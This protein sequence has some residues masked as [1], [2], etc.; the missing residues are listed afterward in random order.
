[1]VQSLPSGRSGLRLSQ[2]PVWST[3][4]AVLAGGAHALSMGMPG[5][6]QPLGTLQWLSLLTMAWLMDRVPHVRRAAW[7]GWVFGTVSLCGT[8]WWLY[9][10]LHTYGH[11]PAWMAAVSVLALCAMLSLYWAGAGWLYVNFRT[12]DLAWGWRALAFGASVMLAELARAQWFTGFPWGVGGYAHVDSAL[13][14]LA[15]WIGVYGIGALSATLAMAVAARKPPHWWPDWQWRQ[16]GAALV[17]SLIVALALP[18]PGMRES[19]RDKP[20]V[21][22]L[23]QGNVPQDEKFQGRRAWSLTWYEAA[24]RS[25]EQGLVVTPETSLP[26]VQ[27]QLPPGYWQGLV[28]HFA[29]GERAAL[30]GM[31]LYDLGVHTNSVLGLA[32]PVPPY[33]YDKHHL[34]PFGEFVPPLFQWFTRMM[35]IPLGEFGRG[36]VDPPSMAWQG[37]RLA[38]MICYEDLFGEELAQ[39]FQDP[40]TSPT[41]L[42]NLSN[43]AWFGDTIALDQHLQISRLRALEFDRPVIRATNTGSTAIID[44]QARVTHRLPASQEG[45]LQG[46]VMGRSGTLTPYAR[47]VGEYGLAPLWALAIGLLWL[48]GR[49]RVRI[50]WRAS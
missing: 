38:P 6:G 8:V 34:V 36:R 3:V 12:R 15:P 43:L 30:I 17:L 10:S 48:P 29:Q 2:S 37:Q 25:V 41:V 19:A 4:A 50:D 18:W 21:V 5:D 32:G 35:N 26:Y 47:W 44:A 1:M 46:E 20:M 42:V 45:V 24:L 33:R 27:Q 23:V 16:W 40:A 7:L 9:I 31:P 28:D 49:T 11:L 39:R 22:H 14:W 13:V